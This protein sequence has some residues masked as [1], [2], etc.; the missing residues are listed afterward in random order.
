MDVNNPG[1]PFFKSIKISTLTRGEYTTYTLVNPILTSW[2]HDDLDNS[3][4]A[5]TMANSMQVAYEAVFYDQE[6]C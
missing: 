1:P 2:S 5:G 6:Y 3:D 4:G